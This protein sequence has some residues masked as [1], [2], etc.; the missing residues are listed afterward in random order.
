MFMSDLQHRHE[1]LFLINGVKHP[2]A[3]TRFPGPKEHLADF[4]LGE[5]F[6]VLW[7]EAMRGGTYGKLCQ[8][9]IKR[10]EPSL[11]QIVTSVA[12][13]GSIPF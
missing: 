3:D 10:I 8:G 1:L 9:L 4:I 5:P 13:I 6:T 7:R 11:S 2:P 12:F